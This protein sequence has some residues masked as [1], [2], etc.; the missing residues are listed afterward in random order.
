MRFVIAVQFELRA[1]YLPNAI[2]CIFKT[3]VAWKSY[4]SRMQ[5]AK[6]NTLPV[7]FKK[8]RAPLADRRRPKGRWTVAVKHRMDQR[9]AG[10]VLMHSTVCDSRYSDKAEGFTL[11]CVADIGPPEE[12]KGAR[13]NPTP[14]NEPAASRVAR[15]DKANPGKSTRQ[16]AADLGV[17]NKTVSQARQAVDPVTPDA[18]VTGRDGKTYPRKRITNAEAYSKR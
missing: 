1:N 2:D 9:E 18:T 4:L 5:T 10:L 12:G 16:V 6:I 11:A 8:N 3:R 14:C 7:S 13:T 15:Y 17:S